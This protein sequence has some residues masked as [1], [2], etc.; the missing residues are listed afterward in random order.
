MRKAFT[1]LA[2]RRSLV[3]NFRCAGPQDRGNGKYLSPSFLLRTEARANGDRW[4]DG[5]SWVGLGERDIP[6]TKYLV[7]VEVSNS[8]CVQDLDYISFP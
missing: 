2:C 5:W 6:S 4:L 3:V 8:R 1:L 7:D